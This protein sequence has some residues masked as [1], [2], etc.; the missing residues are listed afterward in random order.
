MKKI[1]SKSVKS[2]LSYD[3]QGNSKYYLTTRSGMNYVQT[4]F[5]KSFNKPEYCKI[6]ERGNDAPR[7]G[8]TGEYVVVEFTEQFYSDFQWFLDELKAEKEAEKLR[9]LEIKQK[10][11]SIGDQTELLKAL[12]VEK[13]DFLAK[14]K[15]RIENFSSKQWRNWVCMKVC[16]KISEGR[17]ELLTL[18]P[19]E[20]REIAYSI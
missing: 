4:D 10:I 20:I 12:F 18:S 17:F 14:I 7:G 6:I 16:N 13:P 19:S 15:D 1:T 11:E 3:F 8:K 9:L 5:N 2:F